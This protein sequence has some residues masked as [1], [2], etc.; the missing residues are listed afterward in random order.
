MKFVL[1]LQC[2][3]YIMC[4]GCDL[5]STQN[6]NIIDGQNVNCQICEFQFLMGDLSSHFGYLSVLDNLNSKFSHCRNFMALL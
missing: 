4:S 1:F 5:T 3:D 6:V 2:N